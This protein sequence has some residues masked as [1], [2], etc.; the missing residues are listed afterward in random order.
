MMEQV[1]RSGGL[2]KMKD[3]TPYLSKEWLGCEDGFIDQFGNFLTR[4]EAY[5]IAIANNQ[6]RR[7]FHDQE[8]SL[9]SENLY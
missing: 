9:Y 1:R 4:E 2:R 8:G 6:M 5:V 3:G 7:V